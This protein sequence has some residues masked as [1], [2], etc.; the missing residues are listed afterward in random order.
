MEKPIRAFIAFDLP[1][2]VIQRAAELQRDLKSRGLK[3]RWV[4]PQNMHLTVKF[5]GDI[6]PDRTA[7]LAQAMAQ[8][9]QAAAPLELSVQGIGVFPGMRRPRILWIGLGGQIEALGR[10]QADLEDALAA[11]DIPKE[12][13]PFK[14]HLTLARMDR[15][16]DAQQLLQCIEAVGRFEPSRFQ[17]S[18]LILYQSDL[19]PQGPMYIPLARAALEQATPIR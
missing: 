16:V 11:L 1:A 9:A 4:R 13:R 15:R 2:A 8:A 19:R 14:A 18:E 5:L 3:L 12:S 6:P 10:L 17:A 7:G